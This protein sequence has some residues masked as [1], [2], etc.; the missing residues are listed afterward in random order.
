M[1]MRLCLL[2]FSCCF[3]TGCIDLLSVDCTSELRASLLV[4]VRDALTGAPA[5]HG[6]TGTA[7]HVETLTN[8]DLFSYLDS[9]RLNGNWSREQAGQYTVRIQKPGFQNE[10]ISV[11]VTED[12][13]HVRTP[14]VPVTLT[15][16]AAATMITPLAFE[17]GAR[18]GGSPASVGVRVFGDTL[19]VSG[20]AG[21]GCQEVDAI[22]F[23]A[24]LSW[25]I[26]LQPSRWVG[27]CIGPHGQQ[28]FEVR[29]QLIPGRNDVLITNGLE[30]PL[31][32]F[33]GR[34]VTQ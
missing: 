18:V 5:A 25:H 24:G 19:V 28:Q 21:T 26:Q 17:R 9:L 34:V 16:N 3:A 2:L 12:R 6:T 29:Y 11:D 27:P 1:T 4:E 13:C 7:T 20:R 14:R 31:T 32:L 10:Q 15:T 23:R 33:S 8:T 22:A 30:P